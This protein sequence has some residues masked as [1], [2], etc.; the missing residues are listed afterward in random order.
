MPSRT[1]Q[2]GPAAAILFGSSL[3]AGPA[4]AHVIG[5]GSG[6]TGASVA[7]LLGLIG[8]VTGAVARRR[9]T[10]RAGGG[11]D[12]AVVA[13][14]LG[15]VGV[16]LAGLHLAT[17]PGDIGTGSGRLGAIVALVLG[18][19]GMFLGRLAL[20]AGTAPGREARSDA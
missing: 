7:A 16:A 5:P 20:R 15:V 17:S 1:L 11:R 14:V 2:R 4:A 18:V 9:S 8:T 10:S 12:G 19:M 6:R 3:L 13:L